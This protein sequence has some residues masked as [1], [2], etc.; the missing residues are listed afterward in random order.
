MN[1]FEI[2]PLGH[3]NLFEWITALKILR[4]KKKLILS[5][6]SQVGYPTLRMSL[7]SLQS[8]DECILTCMQETIWPQDTKVHQ[9]NKRVKTQYFKNVAF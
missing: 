3:S 5:T 9:V 6:R 2:R 7:T 8:V 1:L 4:R